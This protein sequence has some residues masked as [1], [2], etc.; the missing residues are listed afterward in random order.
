MHDGKTEKKLFRWMWMVMLVPAGFVCFLLGVM[1]VREKFKRC[2]MY[3]RDKCRHVVRE[4]SEKVIKSVREIS[5]KEIKLLV[6]VLWKMF[7]CFVK[8]PCHIRR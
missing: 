4:I 3:M 5:E 1:Q 8:H 7:P 6:L 2:L